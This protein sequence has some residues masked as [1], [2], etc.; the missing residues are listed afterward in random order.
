MWVPSYVLTSGVII[1]LNNRDIRMGFPF[2]PP[3]DPRFA[4]RI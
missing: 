1:T 3:P 4:H 2:Q